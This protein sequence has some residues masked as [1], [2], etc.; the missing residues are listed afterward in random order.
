[1]F[2]HNGSFRHFPTAVPFPMKLRTQ[3]TA[4][5]TGSV[6]FV[7]T[8]RRSENMLTDAIHVNV[9]NLYEIKSG[10]MEPKKDRE[11][12]AEAAACGLGQRTLTD[13]ACIPP[14]PNRASVDNT[15]VSPSGIDYGVES[16]WR[17]NNVYMEQRRKCVYGAAPEMCI[18]SSAGMK[19]RGKREIPKK[20]TCLQHQKELPT[21]VVSGEY[22]GTRKSNEISPLEATEEVIERQKC[23]GYDNGATMKGKHSGLQKRI[24]DMN[25]RACPAA[26]AH[27]AKSLAN[28]IKDYYTFLSSLVI[29]K[30]KEYFEKSKTED[31]FKSYLIDSKELASELEILDMTIGGTIIA[32]RRNK[33][34]QFTYEGEDEPS[35]P[36]LHIVL[37]EKQ[38]NVGTWIGCACKIGRSL[39]NISKPGHNIRDKRLLVQGIAITTMQYVQLVFP[40]A[41][42]SKYPAIIAR[43]V[44][45]KV[46]ETSAKCKIYEFAT[47]S[48]IP[49]V[50]SYCQFPLIHIARH[51]LLISWLVIVCQL[52]LAG[53]LTKQALATDYPACAA[54][55]S[56][57]EITSDISEV[58]FVALILDETTDILQKLHRRPSFNDDAIVIFTTKN[59]RIELDSV[60][61]PSTMSVHSSFAILTVLVWGC[62]LALW[63]V[64][65][66]SLDE[67]TGRSRNK[68][69]DNVLA[70]LDYLFFLTDGVIPVDPPMAVFSFGGALF[71]FDSIGVGCAARFARFFHS[72]MLWRGPLQAILVVVHGTVPTLW[73]A[74]SWRCSRWWLAAGFRRFICFRWFC[75]LWLIKE[76]LCL[77]ILIN[78]PC[79]FYEF[80][81]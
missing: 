72:L 4:I 69:C 21:S 42:L 43:D 37:T 12:K 31:K 46:T 70:E 81:H 11:G 65:R 44:L 19:G 17:V 61:R 66:M 26:N 45:S 14:P 7:T 51:F 39:S 52:V 53:T 8:A 57:N 20:T 15:P 27:E 10:I 59:H 29:W 1:M 33:P 64:L 2:Y 58:A 13:P 56:V 34:K 28:L 35:T 73:Q 22:S 74:W 5:V 36:F 23:Q 80:L 38:L 71:G 63:S 77:E 79:T 30:T 60:V 68:Q 75:R 16:R 48:Q 41:I 49:A 24:L 18:W 32:Q 62:K 55:P 40:S 25:K 67:M 78:I 47:A 76:S 9:L 50:I 54:I 3:I 6:H